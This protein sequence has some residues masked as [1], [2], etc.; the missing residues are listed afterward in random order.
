MENGSL[1]FPQGMITYLETWW[2]KGHSTSVLLVLGFR[3]V[4]SNEDLSL[5]LMK[6]GS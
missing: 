3:L 6:I 2:S 5:P 1:H 4:E